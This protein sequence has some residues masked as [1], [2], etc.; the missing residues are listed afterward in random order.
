MSSR[1]RD[2]GSE[3]AGQRIRRLSSRPA[4]SCGTISAVSYDLAV[5]EGDRPAD[6]EVA[7]TT[8]QGLYEKYVE[9]D[10]PVQPSPRLTAYVEALLALARHH[11]RS[12]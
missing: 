2:D 12:W 3:S 5:W 10:E 9:A 8:F 11:R 7:Y 4:I 6:N 1:L